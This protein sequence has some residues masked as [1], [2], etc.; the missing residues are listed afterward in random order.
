[1]PHFPI[2]LP[3]D[4]L[5]CCTPEWL[6]APYRPGDLNAAFSEVLQIA[7]DIN[8]LQQ[9]EE[10]I[11]TILA[12]LPLSADRQYILAM[13]TTDLLTNAIEYGKDMPD[14]LIDIGVQYIPGI[15]VS[16][17]ITDTLG[18]IPLEKFSLDPSTEEKLAELSE[19]GRGIYIARCT[20]DF[21]IYIP[22]QSAPDKEI[23][24][25]VRPDRELTH[26]EG[27]T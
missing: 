8:L 12:K 21:V 19:H 4:V 15:M 17:G 14:R 7:P 23:L 6:Q 13:V 16:V 1:M 20:G 3:G 18:P 5:V 9:T 24:I 27:G 10:K 2:L 26:S 25:A 11:S 22:R